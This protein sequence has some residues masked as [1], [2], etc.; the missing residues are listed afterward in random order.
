YN[1][2]LGHEVTGLGVPEDP[3]QAVGL[4][5]LPAHAVGLMGFTI[6]QPERR[7]A[8][9]RSMQASAWV[10]TK[11]KPRRAVAPHRAASRAAATKL[12]RGRKRQWMQGRKM[13]RCCRNDQ[14]RNRQGSCSARRRY[15]PR[16]PRPRARD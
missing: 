9:F 4:E 15:R 16:Y 6:R 1:I 13:R 12:M 7:I 8:A 5:E 14:L 11:F 2:S 3:V 10:A